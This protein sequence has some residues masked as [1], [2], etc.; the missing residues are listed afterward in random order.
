MKI[1]G[2]VLAAILLMG[3]NAHAITLYFAANLDGPSESP[4]VPTPGFGSALITWDTIAHNMRV[5]AKYFDLVGPAVTAAH[6]HCCT[7]APL[8]G[9]AGVATTTPTFPGFPATTSG[10]YDQ[11]FDMT[12]STSYNPSFVTASGSV[13]GAEA[14]LLAGMLDKRT[15][16]NI[17]TTFRP[18]GEIRGFLQSI[19]EPSSLTLLGFALAGLA[20]F[21]RKFND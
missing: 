17:H 16:F 11:T 15:Y 14:A 1:G 2:M 8:T 21:R 18:G 9:T 7:A 4:A 20:V 19:P 5:Q 12:L 6:I 3:S 10:T 13:A